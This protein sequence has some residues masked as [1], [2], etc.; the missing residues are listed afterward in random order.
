MSGII[1]CYGLFW[2]EEDVFWGAGRTR[3]Q[4]LGVPARLRTATPTDFRQQVGIYVLYS[5]HQM[6]YVGQTGSGKRKLFSRLK[7]H[8]RDSLADRWDRFSWFGLRRP[9]TIGVRVP[10]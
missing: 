8:R 1:Q 2:R 10:G 9:G 6:I 3:G 5:G 7:A 4:L